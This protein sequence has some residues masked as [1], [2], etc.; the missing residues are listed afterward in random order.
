MGKS[1]KNHGK[2]WEIHGNSEKKMSL[3][4]IGES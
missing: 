1:M 4:L 2:I 3:F